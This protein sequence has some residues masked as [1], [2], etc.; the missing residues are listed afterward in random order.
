MAEQSSG[1]GFLTPRARLVFAKLRQAFIKVIILHYF[2]LICYMWVKTNTS[3]YA[4]G[5]VL[6]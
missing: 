2:D 6:S 3:E 5:G 4:I 1:L